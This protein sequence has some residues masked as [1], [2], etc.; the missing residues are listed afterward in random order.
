[1]ENNVLAIVLHGKSYKSFNSFRAVFE[2]IDILLKEELSNYEI[3]RFSERKIN[4]IDFALNNNGAITLKQLL[5]SVLVGNIDYVP[6]INYIKQFINNIV[7]EKEEA[8]LNI[9]YGLN[10]VNDSIGQII[11]DLTMFMDINERSNINHLHNFNII[12]T[13]LYKAFNWAITDDYKEIM[14]NYE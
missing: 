7:F 14:N 9:K 2:D 11:L 10:K 13:E 3:K 5:N 8:S 6:N 1:M 12:N 4:I